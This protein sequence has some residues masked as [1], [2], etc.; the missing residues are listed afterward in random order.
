[1][2]KSIYNNIK[3]VVAAFFV[4][5]LLFSGYSCSQGT[6]EDLITPDENFKKMNIV[7]RGCLYYLVHEDESDNK[8]QRMLFL[9]S[10]V[11]QNWRNAYITSFDEESEGI[12]YRG[13]FISC[14]GDTANSNRFVE[15]YYHAA[16]LSYEPNVFDYSANINGFLF[17]DLGVSQ[18]NLPYSLDRDNCITSTPIKLYYS[19]LDN[20]YFDTS[21][22]SSNVRTNGYIQFDP[23]CHTQRYE[24]NFYVKKTDSIARVDAVEVE[25]FGI[26]CSVELRTGE[27]DVS[28]VVKARLFGELDHVD[29][30]DPGINRIRVTL[31]ALPLISPDDAAKLLYTEDE[32]GLMKVKMSITSKK[33]GVVKDWVLRHRMT[34]ITPADSLM[35]K[36]K[37][38]DNA[39]L[40]TLNTETKKISKASGSPIVKEFVIDDEI[41]INQDTINTRRYGKWQVV[42]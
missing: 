9:V 35:E 10:R 42:K 19:Y 40:Y 39:T 28:S 23:V 29:T 30:F 4:T 20:S 5:S 2:M 13:N 14:L 25:V 22:D 8:P 12:S 33:T 16:V 31:D 36:V 38:V 7:P 34:E 37:D 41:L 17:G 21:V 32:V 18:I 26:P 27:A 11:L 3:G 1:M 24:W 15:S 6:D